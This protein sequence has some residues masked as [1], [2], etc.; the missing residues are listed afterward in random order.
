MFEESK[1]PKM[2]LQKIARGIREH[3]WFVVVV[4]LLVVVIGLM[5]AFQLDRWREAGNERELEQK[6]LARLTS[7]LESDIPALQ[8]GIDLQTI[9]L[10]MS[11]LLMASV[12][13][14]EA[15]VKNPAVFLAAVD[16][17]AFT[18]TPTLVSHTFEDLRATGNMRLIQNQNL[19][20]ALYDYY[21]YDETQRQYR[22][23]EFTTEFRHFELVA[24]VLNYD[25]V[26]LVQD[27]ILYISP[28]RI[29]EARALEVDTVEVLLAAKRLAERP[30]VRDWLPQIR[31]MQLEQIDVHRKRLER[32]E[33]VLTILKN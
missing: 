28:R 15:A 18:F 30:Q 33:A 1:E 29:E 26:R 27:E 16:Q 20:E 9:R 25:Q 22:P 23:L 3:D 31:R 21:A 2:I 5:M 14:P 10:E 24:G 32:A 7:D 13:D 11:E 12:E 17:A 8:L 4:E 19:K 6:Y